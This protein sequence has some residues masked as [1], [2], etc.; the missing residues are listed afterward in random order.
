MNNQ[1]ERRDNVNIISV[2]GNLLSEDMGGD[3]MARVDE[4]IDENQVRFVVNLSDLS[5]INSS[6]LSV[7]L[8]I[9]T[10]ARRADGD[11]I[12][13]EIPEQLTQLLVIT[14]LNAVFK[15]AATVEEAISALQ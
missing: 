15:T 3:V 11:V 1:I 12:L 4:L 7:L 10:K 6:G 9:L 2:D 5:F 13:A 14:K 8:R